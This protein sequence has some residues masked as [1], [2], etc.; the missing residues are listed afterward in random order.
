MMTLLYHVRKPRD[1]RHDI[2]RWRPKEPRLLA[3]PAI[4]RLDAT[5]L[6][7]FTSAGTRKRVS[8]FFCLDELTISQAFARHGPK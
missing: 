7:K 4:S 8:K 1:G 5:L 6:R 3:I 2:S